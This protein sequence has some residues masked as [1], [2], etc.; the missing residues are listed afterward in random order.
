MVLLQQGWEQPRAE[1]GPRPGGPGVPWLWFLPSPT[2][3]HSCIDGWVPQLSGQGV[4]PGRAGHPGIMPA[5]GG[6]AGTD[7]SHH[8]LGLLG[9]GWGRWRQDRQQGQE[10]LRRDEVG[11]LSSCCFPSSV[12]P[13]SFTSDF[14]RFF[15]KREVGGEET[16]AVLLTK[17]SMCC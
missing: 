14:H 11:A 7:V 3:G 13:P 15:S 2:S 1:M 8:L 5:V 10:A 4:A 16:Q 6:G 12:P 9:Q 17:P